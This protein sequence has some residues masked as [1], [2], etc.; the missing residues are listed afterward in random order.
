LV[1]NITAPGEGTNGSGRK[2]DL[3][4]GPD[5]GELLD[6]YMGVTSYKSV[7]TEHFENIKYPTTLDPL[8]IEQLATCVEDLYYVYYNLG[9]NDVN[10][11]EFPLA[12][13]VIVWDYRGTN[14]NKSSVIFHPYTERFDD[15]DYLEYEIHQYYYRYSSPKSDHELRKAIGNGFLLQFM[16]NTKTFRPYDFERAFFGSLFYWME[17]KWNEP[18]LPLSFVP[19]CFSKDNFKT[20]LAIF[21]KSTN[22]EV[23]KFLA[24]RYGYEFLTEYLQKVDNGI[25]GHIA[26][27]Q[28]I[29]DPTNVWLPVFFQR[30]FEKKV[31]QIPDETFSEQVIDN[32]VNTIPVTLP[33]LNVTNTYMNQFMDCAAKIYDIDLEDPVLTEKSKLSIEITSETIDASDLE[34][35]LFTIDRYSKAIKFIE[36][37]TTFKINDPFDLNEDNLDVMV[38]VVNSQ[39]KNMGQERDLKLSDIQFDITLEEV[40]HLKCNK[41]Q[42]VLDSVWVERTSYNNDTQ[43]YYPGKYA[44]NF[45]FE[46][47]YRGSFRGNTDFSAD[48]NYI[49]NGKTYIGEVTATVDPETLILK[50]FDFTLEEK[51]HI[52]LEDQDVETR[53]RI[54]GIDVQL[55]ATSYGYRG[56]IKGEELTQHINLMEYVKETSNQI[57]SY[58]E[59]VIDFT[60]N[61]KLTV[62][63]VDP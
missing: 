10:F 34:G 36:K 28:T 45:P 7:K 33:S 3:T 32:S 38:V 23:I 17:E 15:D 22:S 50:D 11:P 57:G 13:P 30:F 47:T 58:V 16:T 49:E 25:E 19:S 12:C 2:I 39:T 59:E 18:E 29:D 35:L 56:I 62:T 26:L 24:V 20:D 54:T 5:I 14:E 37:G 48:W 55:E 60:E 46:E 51:Y 63:F 42:I 40:T 21:S 8:V 4:D 1:G 41:M 53:Q 27:F 61:S 43:I 44:F 9:F 6:F 52:S 31:Y